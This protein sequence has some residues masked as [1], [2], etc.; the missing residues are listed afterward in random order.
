MRH[1]RS[2]R[3]GPRAI[4]CVRVEKWKKR[5]CKVAFF[6]RYA[7]DFSCWPTP[8]LSESRFNGSEDHNDAEGRD[9]PKVSWGFHGGWLMTVSPR[10]SRFMR[11]FFAS[12]RI[13]LTSPL[14]RLFDEPPFLSGG[15]RGGVGVAGK[16]WHF[17][18]NEGPRLRYFPLWQ[19]NVEDACEGLRITIDNAVL[20]RRID[21]SR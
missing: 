2:R 1:V 13:S 15:R 16:R 6:L 12:K 7:P 20:A 10:E 14:R 8:S 17:N 3:R 4:S 11:A 9:A 21:V 18:V 19:C 5:G